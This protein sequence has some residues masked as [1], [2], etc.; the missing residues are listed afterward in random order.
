MTCFVKAGPEFRVD[1]R[2]NGTQTDPA[3][4]A[5]ASGGF[6]I[7]WT[8]NTYLLEEIGGAD[9]R[10][11]IYGAAGERIGD[12]FLVNTE[13]I[14]HQRDAKIAGLLGGGFV[15]VWQDF[16]GMR[17]DECGSSI[18]AK[19]FGHGGELV[20]DEFLV[21]LE[22][23][24]SQT[25]PVVAVLPDG[26]FVV[27]W[28]DFSGTRMDDNVKAR[29]FGPD[30]IPSSDEF[31]VNTHTK[32]Y[33]GAPSVAALV[34]GGFVVAWHDF[35][36]TLG[37]ISDG[38]IKAKTFSRTGETVREEFLVN[39]RKRKD[40]SSPVVSALE[41]GGFVV[42]WTD[43]SGTLGDSSGTS[44]K[45]RLFDGLAAPLGD[46]FLV[47]TETAN[48]QLRPALAPLQ[49]GGFV[50][51]WTDH[52]GRGGDASGSGIKGKVFGPRGKTVQDEF[53]VNTE[54]KG[55]QSAAAVVGLV[56]GSFV[57]SWRDAS[58]SQHNAVRLGEIPYTTIKAQI[59][60]PTRK[61]IGAVAH[62][63]GSSSGAVSRS[64]KVSSQMARSLGIYECRYR[65]G[66][67]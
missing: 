67:H 39:T 24:D 14:D 45:A 62:A 20:R 32:N 36:G 25:D 29:M 28:H 53:L 55:D 21:N 9:V 26:G 56:D 35:S 57:V 4:A 43:C 47:N 48:Y 30:G 61:S 58:S 31:V 51:V 38:S 65:G 41:D 17:G 10:A 64:M 16:S 12:E 1:T 3:V 50:V 22:T 27:A 7:T 46:E 15:V 66:L 40:Q 5:L 34:G 19:V 59:F 8:D 6:V 63:D 60:T 13:T 37:D 52:S 49:E 33:Q 2:V 54:T 11:Q 23:R 18:K 42:A 44:I